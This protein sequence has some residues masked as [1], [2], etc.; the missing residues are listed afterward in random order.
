MV[1]GIDVSPFQECWNA[2]LKKAMKPADYVQAV[3]SGVRFAWVKATEGGGWVSPTIADQAQALAAA[4]AYVGAYHYMRGGLS[5]PSV[6]LQ[7]FLRV[8]EH[9]PLTMPAMLDIELDKDE[10]SIPGNVIV[11]WALEWCEG[12]TKAMGT[13]P[14]RIPYIY[15]GA[16]YLDN[17]G[18][19]VVR[20]APY[21]WIVAAYPYDPMK[22]APGQRINRAPPDIS[23]VPRSKKLPTPA[24]WQ[25]TGLGTVP[26]I[27]AACDRIVLNDERFAAIEASARTP[28]TL[29]EVK[30]EPVGCPSPTFSRE[31]SLP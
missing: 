29:P 24:G 28:A 11:D 1:Q 30:I 26:G 3:A 13:A 8:C 5:K 22:P 9:L 2:Q 19:S 6:A 18:D 17:L 21:P 16:T 20:L 27:N 10:V 31:K 4:G 7:T 14:S 12:Y 23:K 15:G 25:W